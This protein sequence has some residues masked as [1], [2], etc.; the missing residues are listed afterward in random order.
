MPELV[1]STH[2]GENATHTDEKKYRLE[3]VT[4]PYRGEAF[5]LITLRTFNIPIG[6]VKEWD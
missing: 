3:H 5:R 4:F 2:N 6:V 1:E